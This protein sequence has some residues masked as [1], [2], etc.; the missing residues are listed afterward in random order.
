MELP[1]RVRVGWIGEDEILGTW[2]DELG[3]EFILAYEVI[4]PRGP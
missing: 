3:V 2:T 1:R 4:R